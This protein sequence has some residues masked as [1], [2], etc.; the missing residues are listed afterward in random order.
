MSA[1]KNIIDMSRGELRKLRYRD[2]F[3]IDARKRV[4]LY[5]F[6]FLQHAER[7]ADYTVDW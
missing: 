3:W 4:Y 7:S 5:W 6:K 2:G 1:R